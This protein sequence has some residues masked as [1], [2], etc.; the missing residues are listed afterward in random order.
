MPSRWHWDLHSDVVVP[1]PQFSGKARGVGGLEKAGTKL[2]M[3]VD[4]TANDVARQVIEVTR[5]RQHR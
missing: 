1:K 3:N 4:G 5:I 2:A